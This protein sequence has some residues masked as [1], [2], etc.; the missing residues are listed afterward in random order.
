MAMVR[1]AT[2]PDAA[3]IARIYTEGIEDRVAT[4]ETEPRSEQ[5]V[6]RVLASHHGTH[7]A[8]V[9]V[10]DGA[11]VGFAWIAPYSDR[12]CYA[13]VGE[14]S[15]YVAREQRGS[16]IGAAL[17]T[18]LATACEARGFW[19]L[20]SRIFPENEA[21]RRL[22]RATGFR[23]VGLHQRHARLDGAWRD[24]IVVERLLGPEA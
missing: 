6:A 19:K 1:A 2:G 11:V 8:V 21:S 10:Q 23:E 4:F 14:F 22:C 24:V 5:D 12:P 9:A 13:G 7:P 17:I 16:G 15:V 3:A 18:A 20:V